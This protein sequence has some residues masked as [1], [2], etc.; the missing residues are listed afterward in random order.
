[1]SV[2]R[3]RCCQAA[4]RPVFREVPVRKVLGVYGT[5]M[6]KPSSSS[7]SWPEIEGSFCLTNNTLHQ[8]TGVQD[9]Y[10]KSMSVIC[11]LATL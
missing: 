8:P 2:V 6:R 9:L 4:S 5:I 11:V 7:A 1:M 10:I 3:F